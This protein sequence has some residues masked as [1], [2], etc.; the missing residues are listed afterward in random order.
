MFSTAGLVLQLSYALLVAAMLSGKPR[1]MR[2]LIALAA[3]LILLRAALLVHD[4]AAIVWMAILLTAWLLKL[5]GDRRE[6]AATTLFDEREEAM[7]SGCLNDLPRGAAR[8]FI[9]QGLWLE[10]ATGEILT[11]EGQT[12][13]HIYFLASGEARASSGGRTVGMCRPGD[14]IG[15]ATVLSGGAATATVT[16]V[17]PATFWCASTADVR[18]FLDDHDSLRITIERSFSNA[19]REKLRAANRLIATS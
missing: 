13:D 7:R 14:L 18:Q 9:D 12:V 6:N 19:L 16:L 4:G 15:E 2:L 8:L 5:W 1:L 10:G 3:I 17:S 11:N